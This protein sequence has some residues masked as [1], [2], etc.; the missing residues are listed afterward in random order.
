L[1]SAS[2]ASPSRLC[3]TAGDRRCSSSLLLRRACRK[4]EDGE[5]APAREE[6]CGSG[7]SA[8]PC[9]AAALAE[10]LVL[11][12]RVVNSAFSEGCTAGPG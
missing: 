2:M 8:H 9:P 10:F 11:G 5:T 12:D 3:A 6:R 7:E 4:T 1:R